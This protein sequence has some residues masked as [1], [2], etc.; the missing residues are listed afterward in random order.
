M[1]NICCARK[2]FMHSGNVLA[3]G[4]NT[5]LLLCDMKIAST[6][7]SEGIMGDRK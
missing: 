1:P 6:E 2:C 3:I 7:E 5:H 4:E